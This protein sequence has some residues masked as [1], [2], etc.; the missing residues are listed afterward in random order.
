MSRKSIELNNMLD[1][2][3]QIAKGNMN[4]DKTSSDTIFNRDTFYADSNLLNE[5][6]TH[7]YS[8]MYGIHKK[9][10]VVNK[11]D[12]DLKVDQTK[13]DTSRLENGIERKKTT[14]YE[15]SKIS[16][17]IVGKKSRKKD[18]KK[19]Q[20]KILTWDEQPTPEEEL[21]NDE[22]IGSYDNEVNS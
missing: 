16:S 10:P 21:E 20:T 9:E 11:F 4:L 1:L 15:D 6:N 14:R 8:Y 3:E 2:E 17:D 13:Q 18:K 5:I 22:K 12:H 19:R 7:I